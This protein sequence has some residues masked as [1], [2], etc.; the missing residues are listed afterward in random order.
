MKEYKFKINGHDY[1][2]TIDGIEGNIAD[3]KAS[4]SIRI[5]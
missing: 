3:V 2:V 5:S 4:Q 1:A